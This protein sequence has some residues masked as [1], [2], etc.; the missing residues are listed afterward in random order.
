MRTVTKIRKNSGIGRKYWPNCTVCKYMK[1]NPAFRSRFV[2]STYFNT[3]GTESAAE[4]LYA[5]HMPFT[6]SLMYAHIRRHMQSQIK[7]AEM[8]QASKAIDVDPLLIVESPTA[9]SGEHEQGLDDFINEGR[10][11]LAVGEL[12]I[13]ATSFLQAIKIKADIEKSTKDRRL[14]G[15][16]AFFSTRG[17]ATEDKG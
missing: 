9:S 7:K 13:N 11:K 2:N 5:Y 16:K 17:T 6:L 15:I 10:A 8:I 1:A 4:V 3:D 12:Q 14:D